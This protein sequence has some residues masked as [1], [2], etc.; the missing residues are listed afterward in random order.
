MKAV[1]DVTYKVFMGELSPKVAAVLVALL[2]LQ[3][4][5]IEAVED[6]RN[7]RRLNYFRSDIEGIADEEEDLRQERIRARNLQPRTS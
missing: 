6:E 7:N 3:L 2:Q 1:S 4:R 5:V